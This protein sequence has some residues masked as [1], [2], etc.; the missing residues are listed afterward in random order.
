MIDLS[1]TK[2]EQL[3]KIYQE[4]EDDPF[5]D[6]LRQPGIQLV[7]G[8]GPPDAKI[9]IVGEAPGAQE[10]GAGRPFVGASGRV[11]DQLIGLMAT[12]PESSVTD[13]PFRNRCFV[14]N[15]VKYRPAGNAT[16]RLSAILHARESLRKEWMVVRPRLTIAV[17]TVAHTAI[18]REGYRSIASCRLQAGQPYEY[19]RK[20]DAEVRRYCISIYHPAYAMHQRDPKKK[21]QI[22]DMIER[23]WE[24]LG[25][26]LREF[27]PDV[28]G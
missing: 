2:L 17:G 20:S 26:W 25:D 13:E 6:Y 3:D 16:P 24:A 23:D 15:V 11:M 5:W 14:T 21:Q 22:Q 4:I 28:L 1:S 12:G 18:H 8:D 27:D 9:M 19:A 7:R 10:N